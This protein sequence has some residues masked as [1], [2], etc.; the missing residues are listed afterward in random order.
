MDV[1]FLL[2][3]NSL[4]VLVY[5]AFCRPACCIAYAIASLFPVR[6]TAVFVSTPDYADNARA[7]SDYIRDDKRFSD[8]NIVWLVGSEGAKAEIASDGVRCYS[9]RCG[10]TGPVAAFLAGA[11]KYVFFTHGFF[12]SYYKIRR[13]QLVVNLWHGCG[14]KYVPPS[15]VPFSY[16][17]VPG[18]LFIDVK[19]KSF[20]CERDRIL[21]IG[22]PRYDRMMRP[23]M[24]A[25]EVRCALKLPVENRLVL[26]LPTF[27]KSI[28]KDYA[29]GSLESVLGLPLIF[30]ENELLELDDVCKKLGIILVV[31]RHPS[32]R[33]YAIEQL[34]PRLSNIIFLSQ[35]DL[36]TAHVDLYELFAASDALISDYSSAAVD[37]L[38]LDR[39]LG[40]VLDDFDKYASARGFCLKNIT[41]YMPGAH[42]MTTQDLADFLASIAGGEDKYS[43]YRAKVSSLVHNP[44]DGYCERVVEWVLSLTPPPLGS[45][46]TADEKK[47]IRR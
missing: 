36:V 16:A 8:I 1:R 6:K 18:E 31:K 12:P 27:R 37:Y 39:P 21:P 25:G 3:H 4:P 13:D 23:S 42:I 22:Y 45:A 7:L 40:Y 24:G 2:K 29:E 26:W 46:M 15:H 32:Q 10:V 20:S 14:Y 44:C 17:L 38:L 19:A 9:L 47:G 35:E 43:P 41:D 30:D 28:R 5:K 11:A 34:A 33:V